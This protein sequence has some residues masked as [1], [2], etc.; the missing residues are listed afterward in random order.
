VTD[1]IAYLVSQYPALSHT[2]V[3]REIAAL[4]ELGVTVRTYSVRPADP[5][6]PFPPATLAEVAGTQ[7][8]Q[9]R[10]ALLLASPAALLAGVRLALRSGPRTVKGRIWQLLYLVEAVHLHRLL[11]RDG[12]TRLHVHHANNAADI[13]RLVVAIGD[14]AARGGADWRWSLAMHGPTEFLDPAGHDLPAKL[15]S[16][17]AVACISDYAT[18]TALEL[19]P[20]ADRDRFGLVRMSAP[21]DDY[22]PAGAQ[23]LARAPGPLSVLFVGRLVPEKAPGLLLDAVRLLRERGVAVHAVIAGDGP[24]R[25]GLVARVAAEGLDV[26]IAG[27]VGQHDLPHR[28]AAADV[29]CLPSFAEGIPVVLMEA[30]LT[31]LPVVT[32]TIAGIP[33]LV[34]AD[35]GVLVP[36]GDVAA[37]ADALQALAADP[38]RRLELGR[39]GRATVLQRHGAAEN[40]Q[41]LRRLVLS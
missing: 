33:E 14:R 18:R 38:A 1:R 11:Q 21:A 8:L 34:D 7:V 25:Q 29:F 4:R 41:R 16:A 17:A 30:M 32:T 27:P 37:V 12:L 9:G 39:R 28:Y 20:Q 6:A 31:E 22:E 35:S 24:L 36:P 26:E 23:R 10:P 5:A 3:E 19:A 2:F 15:A 40:A 13:A